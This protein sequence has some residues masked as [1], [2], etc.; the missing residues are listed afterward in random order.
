MAACIEAQVHLSYRAPRTIA[1]GSIP[2]LRGLSFIQQPSV[3]YRRAPHLN[4]GVCLQH[5]GWRA[6]IVGA[7]DVTP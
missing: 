1:A 4:I 3:A 7:A 6:W 2:R 5:G